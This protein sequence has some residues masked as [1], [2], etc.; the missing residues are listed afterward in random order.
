[1]KAEILI[2][3]N[4]IY[5]EQFEAPCGGP[6]D[7]EIKQAWEAAIYDVIEKEG[8]TA[9]TKI[10][11]SLDPAVKKFVTV[12]VNDE[13]D[14]DNQ[15]PDC[16]CQA[17]EEL[18]DLIKLCELYGNLIADRAS[19]AGYNAAAAKSEEFVKASEQAR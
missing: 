7:A 5:F 17:K 11:V 3:T 8:F 15:S 4:R 6:K 10:G 19:E 12:E 16:D 2:E 14:C 18:H 13:C 9:E 1:M